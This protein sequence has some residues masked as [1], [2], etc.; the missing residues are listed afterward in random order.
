MQ[1]G[2]VSERRS[3]TTPNECKSSCGRSYKSN[4]DADF[5]IVF[6]IS[7][8]SLS[9]WSK[10]T[11]FFCVSVHTVWFSTRQQTSWI[12]YLRFWSYYQF[13]FRKSWKSNGGSWRV[14]CLRS[15]T[16]TVWKCVRVKARTSFHLRSSLRVE[17][18][19]S[20]QTRRRRQVDWG[21]REGGSEDVPGRVI[22]LAPRVHIMML[23]TLDIRIFNCA[24]LTLI[25]SRTTWASAPFSS[26]VFFYRAS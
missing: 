3:A 8:I 12:H 18:P 20:R 25:T 4:L 1:S 10:E 19:R 26:V 21:R 5:C 14:W 24:H 2:A 15:S 16:R 7:R 6:D 11:C 22:A 13:W 9:L 23:M 17:P